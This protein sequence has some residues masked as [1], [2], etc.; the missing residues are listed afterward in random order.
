[1]PCALRFEMSVASNQLRYAKTSVVRK[2]SDGS[3]FTAIF[4][5]EATRE[6]ELTLRRGIQLEVLSKDSKISGDD[7]WWTGKVGN[8]VGIFPS[9]FVTKEADVIQRIPLHIDF[10]EL[11]L[12][13]VIG[14]GGFGKV[15]HA[16]WRKED[17]AVKIAHHDPDEPGATVTNVSQEAKLFWLLD[18]P[19]IVSLR[20]V[21]LKEPNLC[22]VME[23][24]EGGSLNRVLNGRQI[25]PD[26]LVDWA[27]QIAKG[28]HYLHV[29]APIPLIH[30]DLKSNNSKYSFLSLLSFSKDV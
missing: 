1:M 11:K 22:L 17:V 9:N 15:F 6:D 4:D 13:D 3:F 24:A 28:M 2:Q 10:K 5:Y 27:M 21:C 12:N 23:Y 16:T 30:R 26:I 7:G 18:H 8:K 29:E 20:G 25:P 14:V 19:N